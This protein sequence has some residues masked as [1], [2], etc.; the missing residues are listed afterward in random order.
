[1]LLILK[2]G[3]KILLQNNSLISSINMVSILSKFV[4]KQ[5]WHPEGVGWSFSTFL[6]NRMNQKQYKAVLEHI[7]VWPTDR[8]L[9][10][11]FG[12][13][14]L[15]KKILEQRP[16]MVYG[17]DISEDMVNMV[18]RKNEVLL[19]KKLDL[20]LADVQ[21]LSFD[22]TF[23]DKIYTVNTLYF[24]KDSEKSF[25]EIERVLKFWGLFLNVIYTKE[26]L[27]SLSYTKHWFNKYSLEE[28]QHMTKKSGLQ[29]VEVIPISQKAFCVISQKK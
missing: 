7:H 9:D 12:N 4:A 6:M 11:G 2:E 8:V 19:W 16:Q 25:S 27:D 17:I 15:I 26:W 14:Y 22:T 23:F 20:R 24:W 3:N 13:G 1:M 18:S 10:I 5:F 28:V 21:S 29:I